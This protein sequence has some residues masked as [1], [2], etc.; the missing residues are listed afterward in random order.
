MNQKIKELLYEAYRR[1]VMLPAQDKL[2]PLTK[3]WLGLGTL[4]QYAPMLD[5]GLMKWHD[6]PSPPPHCPG[7]LCL[8]D[9]GAA[10]LLDNIEEF[11][12]RYQEEK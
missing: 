8:T 3:R 9:Q 10:L 1:N 11:V 7:W 12:I 4:A 5:N 6:F 2:N